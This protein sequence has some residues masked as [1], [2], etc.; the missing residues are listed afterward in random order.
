MAFSSFS[1]RSF[2]AG[3][4]VLTTVSACEQQG[5]SSVD[6]EWDRRRTEGSFVVVSASHD[7]AVVSALGRQVAIEP[8]E[9]FC[10]AKESIETSQKSAFALIGDCALD[11]PSADAKRSAR[12][13]L[14]LPR[15]VPGII[16][17]SVSGD[18]EFSK[19]GS[20]DEALNGLSEFLE[21]PRGRGMLG[22]GGD[23][24]A[25]SLVESRR[26]GNGV[27]ALVEDGDAGAVPIL[28]KRFWRA[29]VELNDRLAVVTVSGFKDNPLGKEEMLKYLV[30]QVQTLRVANR[31]PINEEQQIL[32]AEANRAS[33]GTSLGD[34]AAQ[35]IRELEPETVVIVTAEEQ[36]PDL[37][38]QP[39]K[40]PPEAEA[41]AQEEDKVQLTVEGEVDPASQLAAL[42]LADRLAQ[43]AGKL[44]VN[45]ELGSGDVVGEEAAAAE[46]AEEAAEKDKSVPVP[47]AR[48]SEV[49]TAAASSDS[50]AVANDAGPETTEPETTEAETTEPGTTEAEPQAPTETATAEETA[51]PVDADP[52]PAAAATEDAPQPAAKPETE[53]PKPWLPASEETGSEGVAPKS[54]P[55]ARPRP[56]EA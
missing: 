43:D 50:A 12:G 32:L 8:A 35:S 22:R 42:A 28:D 40:R 19:E 18:P 53:A 55:V 49:E 26:I 4:F 46:A 3:A 13:E 51:A 14:Q 9:G 17:V 54:S 5:F 23:S 30:N 21:T 33:G 20:Q 41:A 1:F 6:A 36:E 7:R 29:F 47:V 27:Y 15:G 25:V 34:A 37:W 16:T 45:A 52:E 24:G 11:G 10:L 38:P 31:L 44:D 2:V 56:A 48:G 39:M